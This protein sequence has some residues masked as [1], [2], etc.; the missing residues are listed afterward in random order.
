LQ[1]RAHAFDEEAMEVLHSDHPELVHLEVEYYM[2][3]EAVKK[4]AGAESR[5]SPS[6]VVVSQ[7]SSSELEVDYWNGLGASSDDC[8]DL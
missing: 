1:I 8:G 4:K 2:A 5:A 6:I 7:D 3:R